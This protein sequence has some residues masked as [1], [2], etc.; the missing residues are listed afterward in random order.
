MSEKVKLRIDGRKVTARLGE[1]ILDAAEEAGIHI[2]NLCYLKGMKGIGACRLCMVEIEGLKAPMAACTARVKE[3]MEVNTQSDKVKEIRRYVID[4]ILSMHPL[5]CMTCTKAGVCRLQRY[6]YEFEIKESSFTRKKFGFPIDEENP[7]I[8]RDPDYCVLCGRCVRVCKE[9]GTAVLD[10]YGR[11]V[12]SRVVTAEDKPLQEAGCTFCGSCVD[13]CPVNALLEADRWRRG[14]EWDYERV[15]TVCLFCGNACSTEV[16]RYRG[17]VAKVNPGAERGSTGHYICAYGRFGFDYINADTRIT[18]PLKREG[19]ELKPVSWRE[20]VS[21]VAGRLKEAG[22]AGI[23]TSGNITNED[24]LTVRSFAE[25]AGIKNIDATVSLY[26]DERSLVGPEGDIDGADLI[27][28]VGVNPSQWERVLPALDAGVRK[29]VA[30]GAKLVVI[31]AGDTGLGSVAAVNIKAEEAGALAALAKALKDRGIEVPEGLSI[32]EAGVGEDVDKAAELYAGAGSPVIVSSPV[33]FEAASNIALMKGSCLSVPVEAN[34]RGVVMMGLKGEG[35]GYVEMVS[36][37]VK[38]LYVMGDVPVKSR[39]DGVDILIVQNSH[40]TDLAREADIVLPSTSSYETG[41]TV[42]DYK[43]RLKRLERAIEP[44]GGSKTHREIL[45]AVAKEMG[46]GM[47]VAKTAD[48]K[49]AVSGFRVETG[50]SEF[51]KRE[52]LI[53]QPGEFMESANS[54]MINGSRLLWLREIESSVAV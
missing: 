26:G 54:V 11:G 18:E 38:V 15:E 46:T 22:E 25:G 30:R 43:G 31:D 3:G 50:A 40:M 13:A 24:A 23:V 2:P 21:E 53:F 52:D 32:P 51:R 8:K 36:G 27:V 44:I 9:Q 37:G 47:E 17:E 48:V 49:K 19:G 1:T 29:A 16:S 10:F 7:F 33:F 34:A 39:P 12:G 4:L 5:D 42:V 35:K 14:R 28:M 20:A 6:A 45:K 41:G